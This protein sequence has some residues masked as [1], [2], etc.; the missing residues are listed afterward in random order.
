[1]KAISKAQFTSWESVG[2]T[3]LCR[4][5]RCSMDFHTMTAEGAEMPHDCAQAG[6]EL[7]PDGV[8]EV[9]IG[10]NTPMP[11]APWIE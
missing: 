8:R 3:A 10:K 11:L 6:A 1:V 5:L 4:S 2:G 9:T 7:L